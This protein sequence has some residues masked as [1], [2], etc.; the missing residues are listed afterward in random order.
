MSDIDKRLVANDKM[1][2]PQ[3]NVA[4]MAEV[5]ASG[6]LS[7]KQRVMARVYFIHAI[8]R[9][10]NPAYLRVVSLGIIHGVL[11]SVISANN[12][13]VN[14]PNA[15]KVRE[16]FRF[17]ISAFAHTEFLVQVIIPAGLIV[18]FFII[19]D[20]LAKIYGRDADY[21]HASQRAFAKI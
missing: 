16:V 4:V 8:K 17:I 11:F 5:S 3:D 14:M 12:I 10:F 19:R 7:L 6:S 2:S 18:T 20:I 21:K 1:N 13:I 9:V 15:L